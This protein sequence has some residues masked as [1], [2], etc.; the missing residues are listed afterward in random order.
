MFLRICWLYSELM[1][2]YG[3]RGN[4][5]ALVERC[6]RRGIDVEV[7]TRNLGERIEQGRYDIFFMGGGQDR[8]QLAV[9]KDLCGKKGEIIRDE[10]ENG[11]SCLAIC[12]GY[13]LFGKFYKP[14]EGDELPGIGV[15]DAYTIA[16][17]KRMIGNVIARSQLGGRSGL[18]IGFEN[19]S[20]ETYLS[21]NISPLGMVEIG[22]GNNGSDGKEGAIYRG[23]VGSYL[24]GS[25]LPKNPS[26]S[27]FLIEKA[28][29]RKG[30][31]L[32]FTPIDES[33]EE[34]ARAQA[35]ERARKSH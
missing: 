23:A 4:V 12:G 7:E 3:D 31:L 32:S 24:H 5:M 22:N 2:I 14:F 34:N 35:I 16:G 21:E 25:L 6:R 19:H 26:I 17:K 11:A 1:N 13:Q 33:I 28:L 29:L 9:A 20:G 15:F 27:D 18:L 8:E 10:I 30:S